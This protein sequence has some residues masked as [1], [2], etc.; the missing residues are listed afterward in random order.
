MN[1]GAAIVVPRA[2]MREP[3]PAGRPPAADVLDVLGLRPPP[4]DTT[5]DTT[6]NAAIRLLARGPLPFQANAAMIGPKITRTLPNNQQTVQMRI[7]APA[8]AHHSR[9]SSEDQRK[10]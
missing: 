7:H 8:R 2:I 6:P 10:R 3:A 9:S 5:P 1:I 4:I